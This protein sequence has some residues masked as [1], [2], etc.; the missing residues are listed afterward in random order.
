MHVLTFT[1][2]P[3][4]MHRVSEIV[5]ILS[6]G[7]TSI[8]NFPVGYQTASTVNYI[9]FYLENTTWFTHSDDRTRLLA[10]LATFLG[11]ASVLVHDSY[12]SELLLL[13]HC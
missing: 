13:R 6:A 5:A 2:M 3:Q 11:L 7:V 12:S 10:L 8:H 9:S 4:P 1:H